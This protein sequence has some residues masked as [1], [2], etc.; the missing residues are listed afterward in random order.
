[1]KD[2]GI[3]HFSNTNDSILEISYWPGNHKTPGF[4]EVDNWFQLMPNISAF[5]FGF[6]FSYLK[7]NKTLM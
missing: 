5:D 2:F 7:F 3:F 1:M 6:K 4:T